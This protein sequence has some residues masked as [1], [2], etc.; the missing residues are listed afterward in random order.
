LSLKKLLNPNLLGLALLLVGFVVSLGV[1]LTRSYE[2][3]GLGNTEGGKRVVQI[4]HWQLEPG[5]REAMQR[6][7]DDYN[8]LP[9]V[10]EANVEVRQLDVTERV[11]A[12][13]LNVHMIS[14][15]APDICERG[16]SAE[17]QGAGIALYF[18]SLGEAVQVPNP[19]NAPRFLPDDIDPELAEA[20][21]ESPW[22]DT[23]IDGMQGGYV[24]ELQDYY[25]VPTSFFGSV[26]IYYN[27]EIF[28]EAKQI[29]REA[30]HASPQPEWFQNLFL[31]NEGGE[32]RGYV[33]DTPGLRAWV[34]GD[35]E[36]ATL[37]RILM[38]CEAI[39][40][41][42]KQTGDDQLVPIAGSSYTDQMF[43]S[44]YR[45]PFLSNYVEELNVDYGPGLSAVET[46][47]GWRAGAWS[48]DDP[49]VK[50]YFDCVR[51]ICSY[52]P[53]GF[54]GLDREQSR[55]RFV[56]AQAGMIATGS[57]DA[58]SILDA[59]V[60]IPVTDDDP[61]GPA[62][63]VTE[64]DGKLYK[65]HQ[66][67]VRIIPFPLPGPGERWH[68]YVGPPSSDAQSNGGANYMIY[69]RSPNKEIALD[70]LR[71]LTSLRINERFNRDAGWLPIVIGATP[72]ANLM[73]FAP[74]SEGFANADTINISDGAAGN[75]ATRATGQIK[76][77]LAG[78]ID[79]QTLKRELET[80]AA[81]PRTGADRV[82]F[83]NW[84]KARDQVRSFD[85]LVAVQA[86]RKL[87]DDQPD[88]QEKLKFAVR[89]SVLHHNG[90]KY[91]RDWAKRFPDQ[92]FPEF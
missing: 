87:L 18:E 78:T 3:G 72:T 39:Q 92:P 80:A 89:Q 71:Y 9:H 10:R 64:L 38:I 27:V 15:T 19:Y 5:Y 16:K 66:F 41:L 60:G 59:T 17:V 35:E 13:V 33:T 90:T 85:S 32:V 58:K 55:R 48:F 91:R 75:L 43:A 36:P 54:L 73:P 57:W 22:R 65:N 8:A 42:A 83:D 84:Q 47:L 7:I 37:G 86:A 76:N 68:E 74:E 69:Q 63:S 82:M 25:S 50:A 46:W 4:M 45:V 28:S 62:D 67:P 12:Q 70:F 51:T 1:V 23:L 77:F 30:M 21:I 52:F 34:Q 40:Q 2:Q 14:G 6:V 44:R 81:D 20:L 24:L 49:S 11:Y 56:T 26:K 53:A 31:R 88:A 61:A 79:Y 29:L